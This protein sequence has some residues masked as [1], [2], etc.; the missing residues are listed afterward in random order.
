MRRENDSRTENA[1]A[2]YVHGNSE[3]WPSRSKR[4]RCMD[5]V[6]ATYIYVMTIGFEN[7][8]RSFASDVS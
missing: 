4:L 7:I 5:F 2:K 1:N 3:G 8:A 6:L